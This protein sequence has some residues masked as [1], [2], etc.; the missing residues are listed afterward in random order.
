MSDV[1]TLG[2]TMALF[3]ADSPGPLPHV[4]GLTLGIGGAESNVAIGLA[5]LGT[6]VTW[7]GAV[8]Q[9]SL[10]DLVVREL[11]AEGLTVVA[12]RDPT[13]PTGLMIKERRTAEQLKVWYYRAGSAGSRL[14]PDDIPVDVVAEARLLHVTGITPALS[15]TAADATSYA[16]DIARQAG[17]LVSFDVNY[18]AG[19]WAA[20]DARPVLQKL[21]AR[22]DIVFAG[23]EEGALVVGDGDAP[24][25]ARRFAELGATQVVIKRGS[26][27]AYAL[28]DG[29]EYDQPVVPVRSI[30]SVGAGDAFVAGYLAELLAGLP[31]AGRLMTAARSGA[32]ACLVLGDWEGAPRRSELALLDGSEPVSR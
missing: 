31:P 26:Q 29:T 28:V 27:G 1:V 6:S 23:E 7:V 22:A 17:A 3:R 5:R 10:G 13:A 15:P 9:D 11:R 24:N 19:V 20:D 18:R 30:D 4:H 32:F 14:G 21:C 16:V 8:G 2:E 25:L 12:R